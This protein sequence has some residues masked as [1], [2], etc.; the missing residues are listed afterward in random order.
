MPWLPLAPTGQYIEGPTATPPPLPPGTPECRAAQ[1]EGESIGEGAALSNVNMPVEVRNRST[2]A[3]YVHGYPDV[4]VFAASGRVLARAIGNEGRGTY[5]G[6]GPDVPVLLPPGTPRLPAPAV[7]L[8][9]TKLEG[10]AFM[11]LSW[12]DCPPLPWASR[13]ALDLPDDTGRLLI[14]FPLQ[15]YYNA[16]CGNGHAQ[17][18]SVSRGPFGATGVPW[19]PAVETIPVMTKISVSAPVSRGKTLVY[20]VT[21]RNE[22]DRDYTLKPC[23]DYFEFLTGMKNGPSYQLNCAPAGKISPGRS[24]TFE[25]R[26]PVSADQATGPTYINWSLADGRLDNPAAQAEVLITS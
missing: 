8:G 16:A 25:M 10:Q 15:A 13:L 1:L 11:N 12:Y 22:G 3:C 18:P 7:P 19:P 17:A 4:T 2:S 5:F 20:F 14:P 24:V 23:P 6:D 9:P 26:L 21:I